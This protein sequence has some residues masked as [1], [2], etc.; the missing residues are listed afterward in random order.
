MKMA[1]LFELY[2]ELTKKEYQENQARKEQLR[3]LK[4]KLKKLQEQLLIHREEWKDKDKTT[5]YV[6]TVKIENQKKITEINYYQTVETSTNPLVSIKEVVGDK[7]ERREEELSEEEKEKYLPILQEIEKIK[8]EIEEVSKP[9]KTKSDEILREIVKRLNLGDDYEHALSLI[10]SYDSFPPEIKERLK[11]L[12]DKKFLNAIYEEN[13]RELRERQKEWE[14]KERE[15]QEAARKRLEEVKNIYQEYKKEIKF[16][17]PELMEEIE[18]AI[19]TGGAR[20]DLLKEVK[21]VKDWLDALRKLRK[22]QDDRVVFSVEEEKTGRVVFQITLKDI[23]TGK[24]EV[25][26]NILPHIIG[27]GGKNIKILGY[28]A[29]KRIEVVPTESMPLPKKVSFK[30]LPKEYKELTEEKK[31]ELSFYNYKGPSL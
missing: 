28:I 5:T 21:S 7:L 6:K 10:E 17:K 11:N 9:I 2:L 29:G 19:Q 25:P 23:R 3:K 22:E 4:E 27:K 8:R 20:E 24:I 12:E 13:E 16:L 26:K 31:E 14:K 30:L 18:R 15:K 1:E